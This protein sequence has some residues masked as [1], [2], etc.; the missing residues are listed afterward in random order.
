[1]RASV[2]CPQQTRGGGDWQEAR[3]NEVERKQTKPKDMKDTD[4]CI[5]DKMR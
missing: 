1:M 4:L 3:G 2:L 5:A